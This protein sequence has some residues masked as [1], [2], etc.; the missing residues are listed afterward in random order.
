MRRLIAL[1]GLGICGAMSGV[2]SHARAQGRPDSVASRPASVPKAGTDSTPTAGSPAAASKS[3]TSKANANT[4]APHDSTGHPDSAAKTTVKIPLTHAD[5]VKRDS[6]VKDSLRRA[7]RADSIYQDTAHFKPLVKWRADSDSVVMSMLNRPGFRATQYQGDSVFFNAADRVLRIVGRPAAVGREQTLVVG[8]TVIYNDSTKIVVA[9]GDTV[10]LRDPTQQSA[11]VIAR[12]RVTYSTESRRASITN[13]RTSVENGQTYFVS[14]KTATF[15]GD[16]TKGKQNTIYIHN[17]I[18]TSCDDSIPDYYFKSDEIKFV[19]PNFIVARP[20]TLYISDVPVFW[21][22]FLFQDIRRGRASGFLVP[23]F[24]VGD[25][26]RNSSNYRREISNIGYYVNLGNYMDAWA[27]LDW[28]SGARATEADPGY[29][30]YN[31]EFNYSWRDRFMTGSLAANEMIE[32]NGER[33]TA[34]TWTHSQDFSQT[35]RLVADVN[36]STNTLAERQTLIDPLA[37][38]STI[39]SDVRYSRKVGPFSVDLGGNRVQYPGRSQVEED[40]PSLSVS[41]PTLAVTSWLDWTPGLQYTRNASKNTDQVGTFS[42]RYFTDPSGAA[43]S[44]RRT[45]SINNQ[46]F[47]FS[48]PFSIKGF[49]ISAAI[50]AQSQENDFPIT[51]TFINQADTSQRFTRTYPQSYV[52][53]LDWTF[54]FSL[55]GFL[56]NTFR[57]RPDLSF[58]NVL[59]GSYWVRTE[60]SHGEFVHQSKRLNTGISMTPTLFALFPGFGPFSRIR[61]SITPTIRFSYS[62]AGHVDAAYLEALNQDPGSFIG[63]L[64]QKQVSLTLTQVFEAKLKSDT[65]ANGEG[66][67][68][69]LLSVNASTLTYDFE[70]AHETHS[71]QGGFTTD[72]FGYDLSSDLLPGVSFRVDYSLFQGS[73]N[74]DTAV[75]KPFLTSI[76]SGFTLNAQSAV[77]VGI[78]RLFGYHPIGTSPAPSPDASVDSLPSAMTSMPVAGSYAR[79]RLFEVPDQQGWSSTI[80]FTSQ[81]QRPP[82]GGRTLTYNPADICAAVASNPFALSQCQ[83]DALQNSPTNTGPYTDAIGGG[84]FIVTPPRETMQTSTTFHIT[85]N[86]S[87]SWST[88]YDIINHSFASQVIT[89]QRELHDW[90]AVFNITSSPNGAFFFSFYIANKA[91][92]ELRMPYTKTSYRQTQ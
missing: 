55:P 82:K 77:V 86:W 34:L 63:N 12:G 65:S 59:G 72:D 7:A 9:L 79:N 84:V 90:R 61:H 66:K 37:I 58:Q 71:R 73:L 41:S 24:S 39:R 78:G 11:D 51:R 80:N 87:A 1:V 8:D 46:S 19:T 89:L 52:D 31:A 83:L 13:V 22:P 81:R 29:I 74:S 33:A 25:I 4:I 3:D 21:I 26:V 92:P 38:L 62:P 42:Y 43:D 23:R 91:Q 53:G 45:G 40:Y 85:T 57:V 60:L 5:S 50:N 49:Q 17:G 32:K 69:K 44:T 35:E 14:G 68:I 67:K 54:G 15:V 10:V 28:R 2:P 47:G 20:A 27:A 70:R 6:V 76:T 88:T 30:R 75:F 16:T 36:F 56:N 18:I 64:P 48:T